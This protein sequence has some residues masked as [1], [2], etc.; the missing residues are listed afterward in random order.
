MSGYVDIWFARRLDGAS[1]EELERYLSPEERARAARFRTAALRA[2]YAFAHDFLRRVLERYLGC[3]PAAVEMAVDARGKPHL[4]CGELWFSLSHSGAA[5]AVA[6]PQA[7]AGRRTWRPR[8][9][10]VAAVAME[11]GPAR[12]RYQKL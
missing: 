6:R 11:T 12:I 2:D 4:A 8:E 1:G 9:G 7:G 10:L 5:A 3:E